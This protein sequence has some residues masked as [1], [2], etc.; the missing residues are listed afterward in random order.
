MLPF[1]GLN[2]EL[3]LGHGGWQTLYAPDGK[4][5]TDHIND[6]QHS[7]MY[8]SFIASGIVD[9]VGYYFGA[10]PGADRA[11]L[12]LAY[13]S[14]F[15]LLVFHLK[16]PSIEILVHLILALQVAATFVAICVESAAPRN[17][18]VAT[19][20]PALTVLQGVWWIQTA[21]IMYVSDPAYDPEEMGGTMMTPVVLVMH[22]LWIAFGSFMRK[23]ELIII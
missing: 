21:Y 8:S 18:V 5:V 6:W 3:W 16:G 12:G 1:I 10:P 22:M 14:Q 23:F 2:G 7:T 20:R 4:F 11:F 13:L 19:L 17:V 9:I 15:L